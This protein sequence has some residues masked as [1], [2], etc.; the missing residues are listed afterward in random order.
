MERKSNEFDGWEFPEKCKECGRF[1][2]H[3]K[4]QPVAFLDCATKLCEFCFVDQE[5]LEDL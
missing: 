3:D 2:N 4:N 1:D 5:Q